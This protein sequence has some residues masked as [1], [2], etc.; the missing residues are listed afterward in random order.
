MRKVG[1]SACLMSCWNVTL[2]CPAAVWLHS[3]FLFQL[4]DFAEEKSAHRCAEHFWNLH[5][6]KIVGSAK[7]SS[8]RQK[9]LL[10]KIVKAYIDL[11]AEKARTHIQY[12]YRR[13]QSK[14]HE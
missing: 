2:K 3:D 9:C 14:R 1:L 11:K 12:K 10:R 8:G 7:C 6:M 5:H 13:A 4:G